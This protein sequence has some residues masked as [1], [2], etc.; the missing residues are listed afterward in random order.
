MIR[1]SMIIKI[2]FWFRKGDTEII[3]RFAR[4]SLIISCLSLIPLAIIYIGMLLLLNDRLNV[5]EDDYYGPV[6]HALIKFQKCFG[7]NIC[8]YRFSL[9]LLAVLGIAAI[10]PGIIIG[11]LAINAVTEKSRGCLQAA[12]VW[13]KFY[14]FFFWNCWRLE[15][16]DFDA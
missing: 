16:G 7:R 11:P 10:S 4:Y 15:C 8:C 2:Q 12:I 9:F 6:D 14:I 1:N 3:E 13:V 5:S